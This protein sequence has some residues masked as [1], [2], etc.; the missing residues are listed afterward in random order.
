MSFQP[1]DDDTLLDYVDGAL[2]PQRRAEVEALLGDPGLRAEVE[3][4]RRLRAICA[5]PSPPPT[6]LPSAR[7]CHLGAHRPPRGAA[8]PALAERSRWAAQPRR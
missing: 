2:D 4:L 6:R 8:R 3:G 5:R 7:P 1:I